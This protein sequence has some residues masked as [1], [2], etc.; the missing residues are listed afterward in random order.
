MRAV[1]TPGNDQVREAPDRLVDHGRVG[2]LG[3]QPVVA[4]NAA[5]PVGERIQKLQSFAVEPKKLVAFVMLTRRQLSNH[6]A[7]SAINKP[8][9]AILIK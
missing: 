6:R 4:T 1:R 2:V 3:I 9:R 8:T 5:D 7:T